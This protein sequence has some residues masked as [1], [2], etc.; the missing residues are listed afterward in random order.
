MGSFGWKSGEQEER[1]RLRAFWSAER[2]D[3]PALRALAMPAL[4]RWTA[5]LD[6]ALYHLDGVCQLRFLD[7]IC[8]LPNLRGIQWAAEPG[9]GSPVLWIDTF[10]KLRERGL[11]LYI[12]A[13]VDDALTI[14][15][16]L[17]PEGLFFSIGDFGTVR[18]AE[19]AIRAFEK[20]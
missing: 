19:A 8:T 15:K 18:E 12:G 3:R 4:R 7:L 2:V 9:A 17:G 14:T 20:R 5:S 1:Q 13:S 16:A 11:V 6:A 10:R